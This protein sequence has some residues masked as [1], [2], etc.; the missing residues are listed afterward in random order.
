MSGGGGL[1]IRSPPP[2]SFRQ[3]REA[4]GTRAPTRAGTRR[5]NPG[6]RSRRSAAGRPEVELVQGAED[7]PR[8]RREFENDHASAGPDGA[9]HLP[10]A[11]LTVRHVPD[12]EGDAGGVEDPVPERE[13]FP[14]RTKECDSSG[15]P[16]PRTSPAPPAS[17]PRR[18]RRRRR[19]LPVLSGAISPAPCRPFLSRRPGIF[20]RSTGRFPPRR[21]GANAS[22]HPATA[23]G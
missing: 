18:G 8:R 11:P 17:S 7:R 1:R 23:A 2:A 12:P 22:P 6:R 14:R 3:S 19:M 21:G 13:A 20:R 9:A 5:R 4:R 16:R 15:L 10:K